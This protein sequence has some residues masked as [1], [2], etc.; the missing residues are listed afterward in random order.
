MRTAVYSIF[1]SLLLSFLFSCCAI[2]QCADSFT[3]QTF[4][5]EN[6]EGCSDEVTVYYPNGDEY[7]V[8]VQCEGVD[9]CGQLFTTCYGYGNCEPAAL[10]S[11]DFKRELNQIASTADVLV[12]DC[13]GH[14]VPYQPRSAQ[15]AQVRSRSARLH[16]DLLEDVL[17]R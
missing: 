17:W 15:T 14:Y 1:T 11:P 3:S 16:R 8:Y 13:G 10:K 2:A 7:G 4:Q 5:C 6:G 12:Q 9:C